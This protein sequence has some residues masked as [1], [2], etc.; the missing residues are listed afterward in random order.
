MGEIGSG[1]K[2]RLEYILD[3]ACTGLP[4]GG[5]HQE[6]LSIA[7]RLAQATEE[8]VT[9]LQELRAVA[10]QALSEIPKPTTDQRDE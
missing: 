9:D 7:G 10:R 1:F 3:E 2:V 6:R 8:G 4:N 5:S